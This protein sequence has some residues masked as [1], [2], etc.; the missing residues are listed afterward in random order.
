MTSCSWPLLRDDCDADDCNVH[1]NLKDLNNRPN[2]ASMRC[3]YFRYLLLDD[4]SKYI[5][6][7]QRPSNELLLLPCKRRSRTFRHHSTIASNASDE[8]PTLK[9]VVDQRP[10]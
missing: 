7:Q 5:H 1:P 10:S 4:A 6:H 8:Q 3:N 9:D 2:W